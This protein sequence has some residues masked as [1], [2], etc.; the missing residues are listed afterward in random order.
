MCLWWSLNQRDRHRTRITVSSF[1]TPGQPPCQVPRNDSAAQQY[2]ADDRL[3]SLPHNHA[4]TATH[5]ERWILAKPPPVEPIHMAQPA[6]AELVA[7][8][9]GECRSRP[10]TISNVADRMPPSRYQ[11]TGKKS[12]HVKSTRWRGHREIGSP[13]QVYPGTQKWLLTTADIRP[14]T[15]SQS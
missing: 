1:R 6:S 7:G 15:Q 11:P 13:A 2:R 5:E 10:C 4:V 3:I 8:V 9:A 14:Y 12:R